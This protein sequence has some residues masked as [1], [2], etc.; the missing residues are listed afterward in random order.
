MFDL[1]LLAPIA[2]VCMVFLLGGTFYFVMG[3]LLVVTGNKEDNRIK[4]RSGIRSMC[5]GLA[6]AI[7]AVYTFYKAYLWLQ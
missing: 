2:L 6:V 1:L 3:L 5:L 7:I 4:K